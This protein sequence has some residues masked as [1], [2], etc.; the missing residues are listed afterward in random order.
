MKYKLYCMTSDCWRILYVE[1]ELDKTSDN[2][3]E[4][5]EMFHTALSDIV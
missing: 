5:S 2:T 3:I 4:T 1:I